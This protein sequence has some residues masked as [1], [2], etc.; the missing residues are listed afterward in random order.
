MPPDP[1]MVEFF[2]TGRKYGIR[3]ACPPE[4]V[5]NVLAQVTRDEQEDFFK[6]YIAG[7]IKGGLKRPGD[8]AIWVIREVLKGSIVP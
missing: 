1:G 3:R 6:G 2:L 5:I 7:V 8:L 4:E